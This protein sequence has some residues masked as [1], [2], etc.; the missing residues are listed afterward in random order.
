MSEVHTSYTTAAMMTSILV[1]VR[2]AQ[3]VISAA[4]IRFRLARPDPEVLL[5]ATQDIKYW[6]NI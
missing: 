4:R 1:R 2:L 3:L 5:C 6:T